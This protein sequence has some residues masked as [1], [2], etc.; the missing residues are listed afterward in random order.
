MQLIKQATMKQILPHQYLR[1]L[2]ELMSAE[3]QKITAQKVLLL[4]A[5]DFEMVTLYKD[6]EQKL[7]VF[8]DDLNFKK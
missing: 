5:K 7:D 8:I 4:E 6:I 2:K 1:E 3:K